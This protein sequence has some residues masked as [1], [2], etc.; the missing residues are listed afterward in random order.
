MKWEGGRYGE[1]EG[2]DS[3]DKVC[4]R[5]HCL[6][7]AKDEDQGLMPWHIFMM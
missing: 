4:R 6:G 1:E 7:W 5:S 3:T 2:R